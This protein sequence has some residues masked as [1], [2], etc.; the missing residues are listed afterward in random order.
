MEFSFWN[1]R[2]GVAEGSAAIFYHLV[3]GRD[4]I[5]LAL[6]FSASRASGSFLASGAVDSFIAGYIFPRIALL[7]GV[8]FSPKVYPFDI[9]TTWTG[10]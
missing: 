5:F 6:R 7:F 3:G 10:G 2:R 1:S 4:A 8:R 9:V